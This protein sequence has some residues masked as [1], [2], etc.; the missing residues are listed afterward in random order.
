MRPKQYMVEHILSALFMLFVHYL[1][2]SIERTFSRQSILFYWNSAYFIGS[3]IVC[4]R[5]STAILQS[6]FKN[7]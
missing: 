7:N 3:P 1:F 6:G 5:F 4:C 2:L